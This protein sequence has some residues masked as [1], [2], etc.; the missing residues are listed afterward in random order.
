MIGVFCLAGF[1]ATGSR[2]GVQDDMN[3]RR[4]TPCFWI[5]HFCGMTFKAS[6][7]GLA[8][9]SRIGVRDDMNG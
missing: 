5:P 8:S 3:G 2:I 1:L 4:Y 9:G 7:V 6:A